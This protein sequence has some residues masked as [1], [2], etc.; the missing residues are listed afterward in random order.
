MDTGG[1]VAM[2][3]LAEASMR[4][5]LGFKAYPRVGGTHSNEVGT[6]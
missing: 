6:D 4:V 5:N 3:Y 2:K 1:V